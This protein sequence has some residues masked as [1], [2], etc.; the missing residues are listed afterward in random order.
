MW[1]KWDRMAM[2]EGPRSA[3]FSPDG[4]DSYC[5]EWSNNLRHGQGTRKWVSKDGTQWIYKGEW[6]EGKRQGR[7]ALY[8]VE[9]GQ[10]RIVYEGEW[11]S[12]KMHGSGTYHFANGDVY[13]GEMDTGMRTGVG[14]LKCAN[15]DTYD[16]QWFANLKEGHGTHL[17][18]NGD[19]YVGQWVKGKKHGKGAF[20]YTQKRKVYEGVW[21]NGVAKCGSMSE[22]PAE[23][24]VGPGMQQAQQDGRGPTSLPGLELKDAAGVIDASVDLVL[25][26]QVDED[27]DTEHCAFIDAGDDD[28]SQQ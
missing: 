17:H 22:I 3:V 6:A 4:K 13:T 19:R 8:R 18:A 2:K 11:K 12:D 7:G 1:H 24:G 5:G 15:G 27:E 21:V 20:Y 9:E 26:T 16:G 10:Q 25:K 14:L 23:L 28:E